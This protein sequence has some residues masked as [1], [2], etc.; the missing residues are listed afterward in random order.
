[1][2]RG[3]S[4][5]QGSPLGETQKRREIDGEDQMIDGE[6]VLRFI[7]LNNDG[8]AVERRVVVRV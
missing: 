4:G 2:P 7:D 5:V 3:F 1:M 6:L 8:L